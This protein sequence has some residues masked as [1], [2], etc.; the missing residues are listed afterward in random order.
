MQSPEKVHFSNCIPLSSES[1]AI[2]GQAVLQSR[3]STQAV[4]RAL[5][6]KPLLCPMC[7]ALPIREPSYP[8]FTN[9][10]PLRLRVRLPYKLTD[11]PT[12]FQK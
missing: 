10:R 8:D 9:L 5:Y 2:A 11:L 6:T 3:A 1:E 12:G 4:I 7:S